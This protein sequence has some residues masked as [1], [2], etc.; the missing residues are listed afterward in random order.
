MK[1]LSR[2]GFLVVA[3]CAL[4]AVGAAGPAFAKTKNHGK[5]TKHTTASSNPATELSAL[6]SQVQAAKNRSFKATWTTSSASGGPT[7]VTL[8]QKPPD[9][10]FLTS[11]GSGGGGEFLA[12]ATASYFC[13]SSSGT[14]TCLKESGPNPLVGLMDLYTGDTFVSAL[15]GYEAE[16]AAKVQ[17]VDLKFSNQSFAGLSAKCVNASSKGQSFKWCVTSSGILAYASTGGKAT[18]SLTSYSTK[19]SASD[20]NL[21][22]GAT[23]A[24]LP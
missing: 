5:H 4:A 10:L 7:T 11:G 23:V 19:V 6:S 3:V 8:E 13:G 15:Q 17:G 22:H 24:T 1:K 14:E 20:F 18:F 21:P 12:T 9:S 16:V 2:A